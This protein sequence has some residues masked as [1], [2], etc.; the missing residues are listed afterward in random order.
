MIAVGSSKRVLE[1]KF[2]VRGAAHD[3]SRNAC[4]TLKDEVPAEEF[5]LVD[6]ASVKASLVEETDAPPPCV[7]RPPD[8]L[9]L[10]SYVDPWSG[11]G[12]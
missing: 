8:K 12:L 4:V 7:W 2:V 6:D 5:P 1:A 3:A 9:V 11:P 10:S